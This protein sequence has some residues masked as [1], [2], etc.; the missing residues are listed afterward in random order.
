MILD[1]A[2]KAHGKFFP[3]TL[4]QISNHTSPQ[5]DV[6]TKRSTRTSQHGP[7]YFGILSI[8]RRAIDSSFVQS[9]WFQEKY[10]V[11]WNIRFSPIIC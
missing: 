9:W 4:S 10:K 6:C 8:S 1:L 7:F 11:A 5:G 3:C 2:F